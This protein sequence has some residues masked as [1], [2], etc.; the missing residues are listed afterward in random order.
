MA[1]VAQRTQPL[2]IPSAGLTLSPPS[3][4]PFARSAQTSRSAKLTLDTLSPVTQNGSFEFDRV[5]KAGEVLKRTRRT[6][7]G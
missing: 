7:V 3:S 5:I 1:D 4:L 2:T 6:K